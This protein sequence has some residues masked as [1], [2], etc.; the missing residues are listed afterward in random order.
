M[1]ENNPIVDESLMSTAEGK[2]KHK[3]RHSKSAG[4]TFTIEG[5]RM[6]DGKFKCVCKPFVCRFYYL[7][8][9]RSGTNTIL[10]PL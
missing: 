3:R 8:L 2:G 6:P 4:T 9:H 10:P 5:D 1:D 7:N